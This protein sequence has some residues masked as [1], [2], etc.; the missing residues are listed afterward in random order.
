M[1]T[2]IVTGANRGLGLEFA[3]QYAA[4]GW[5]VIATCRDPAGAGALTGIDGVEVAALD[6]GDLD[7]VAAFGARYGAE[8]IDLFVNNA[9]TYGGDR[10]AQAFG[11]TDAGAWL[12]TFRINTIAP[13]KLAEALAGGLEKAK[14]KIAI[15]TSKVGSVADN[16]SGGATLYRTSKAA[17]NMVGKN[18]A[19]EL[20]PRGIA[21]VLLH[22]G[23]VKTD[24]G[25]PNALITTEDSVSGMRRVIDGVSVHTSG[26]FYDY[27]GKEIPW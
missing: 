27:S 21:V 12:D 10:A 24:M 15:L 17:V 13:M 7:A 18:L 25:G 22:P 23:W 19:I 20:A 2:V 6:V 16:T 26:R 9:G 11:S 8:A 4:A 5:R 14:G 1:P 3:K